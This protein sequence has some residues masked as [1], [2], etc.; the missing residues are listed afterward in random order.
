[1]L[2]EDEKQ[3]RDL[4]AQ[5]LRKQGYEVLVAA[6][7]EEGLQMCKDHPGPIDMLLTDVVMPRLGGRQVADAVLGMRPDVKVVFMSGYTGDVAFMQGLN[8]LGASFLQKPLTPETLKRKVHEVMALL[9]HSRTAT[10]A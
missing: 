3:V 6:R 7:P 10:A 5:I 4:A 9:A 1:L 8:D 2:V